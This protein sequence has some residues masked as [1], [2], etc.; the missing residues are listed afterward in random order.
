[1]YFSM[2]VER[3]AGKS[4]TAAQ[5]VGTTGAVS[6]SDGSER[7]RNTQTESQDLLLIKC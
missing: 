6:T 7:G 5:T 2:F 4:A 1:M 3:C